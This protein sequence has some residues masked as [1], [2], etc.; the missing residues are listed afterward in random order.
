[1]NEDHCT[2]I[3]LILC[4]ILLCLIIY[5]LKCVY[6]EGFVTKEAID[7]S[8]KANKILSKDDKIS[9]TDFKNKTNISDIVQYD[10]IKKLWKHNNLTPENIQKLL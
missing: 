10:D 6:K 3:S 8:H 4:L 9:F 5:I 2:I 7:L 1:M